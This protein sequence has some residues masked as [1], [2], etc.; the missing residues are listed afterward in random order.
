VTLEQA[1]AELS[2][3][4]AGLSRIYPES[5]AQRAV[6][7]TPMMEARSGDAGAIFYPLL[8][9]VA[10]VLLIA[11]T[12]VANLLLARAASRRREISVRAALGAAR[13]RLMREF[14]ADGVVL[15]AP[16]VLAGLALA[17]GGLALFRAAAPEGFPGVATV[18]V[19][20]AVL[21][22]TVAAGSVAG[23]FSAMVPALQGSQADLTESLKEGARGSVSRKR[24]RFR[25]SLVAGEVGLA[26][27][28]LAGAGL[29]IGT[30][31]RLQ[32]HAPGFDPAGVTVAQFH[33]TGP[34]YMTNAPQREI[35]MRNVEP[36]VALFFEH[37]LR[38]VRTLPGVERTALAGSVPMGPVSGAPGVR[39]RMAGASEPDDQLRSSIYTPVTSDYFE[40]LRIPLRRGR[41][42]NEHDTASGQWVAV[43]NETFARQFVPAG[44]AIGQIITIAAPGMAPVEERPRRIVGVIA[45]HTQYTARIPPQPEVYTSYFQ[46]PSVIPGTMQGQ[47]FRPSLVMRSRPAGGINPEAISRIV[48][49]FDRQLAVSGVKTLEAHI[50]GR[51]APMRFYAYTLGL[52]AT[53][54]I[55]LAAV[56]IYG[57]MHYS[58][59]DRM[60]EI[61]IRVSLGAS[62]RRV[63]WL[64]VSHGLKLA[65]IGIALGIAG[66]LATTRLLERFLF[67][68]QPWDPLTFSFV[69]AAVLAVAVA[70]SAVPAWRTARVDAA[71]AL[72]RE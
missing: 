59:S 50:A 36:A 41:Y 49:D 24:Q 23:V 44:K 18:R 70:S 22:F 6:A 52:F 58:V 7:L 3:I 35:D 55:A 33:L 56:G 62:R 14:L 45:D 21:W 27:I 61:G 38:E 63:V 67:G 71:I 4:A 11:C 8:G 72:R 65:G 16:A 12:N 46:Q 57:L 43:V 28:L 17:Y 32:N 19:N 64:I 20:L 48:A 53:A 31:R 1:Q 5:N 13:S 2:A 39:I 68:I 29:M 40:T 26:L 47:R 42:L 66:A 69:T 9:A 54:A 34:R 51:S 10:F 60:H 15:A 37:V 25:S 30:V